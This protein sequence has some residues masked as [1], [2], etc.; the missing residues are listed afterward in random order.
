MQWSAQNESIGRQKPGDRF[1]KHRDIRST[2]REEFVNAV[3]QMST[4][5]LESATALLRKF[6]ESRNR[7]A[8]SVR[9]DC[10]NR[11]WVILPFDDSIQRSSRGLRNMQK[12][13]RLAMHWDIVAFALWTSNR[14]QGKL[15][16]VSCLNSTAKANA[17]HCKFETT[18]RIVWLGK[19]I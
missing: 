10:E 5:H 13:Q 19:T 1:A 14:Q 8:N 17:S 9:I 16:L 12:N 18:D 7:G 11:D 15:T 2:L 4:H 6:L 3:K